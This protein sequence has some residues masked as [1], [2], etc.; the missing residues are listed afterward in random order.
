MRSLPEKAGRGPGAG[1]QSVR[2]GTRQADRGVDM[3]GHRP[4]TTLSASELA[5]G[6]RACVRSRCFG[7]L[8]SYEPHHYYTSFMKSV[9]FKSFKDSLIRFLHW[10][11]D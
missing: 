2:G 3:A 5:Y 11:L 4:G 1:L 9:P 10:K 7:I 8:D 6:R